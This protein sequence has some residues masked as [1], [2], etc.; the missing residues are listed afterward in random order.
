M[1]TITL[2][3]VPSNAKLYAKALMPKK[4][5]PKA[6]T[7]PEIAYELKG[8]KIKADHVKSY[9]KTCGFPEGERVPACYP[10]LMAM[11]LVTSLVLE[12]K[13]PFKAMGMVHLS[14]EIT[15]L[16]ELFTGD[17][18]DI[19]TH[20]GDIQVLEKGR[21]VPFYTEAKRL[22]KVVWKCTTE[23]FFFGGGHK[24]KE[25]KA[26]T[27]ALEGTSVEW[28]LADGLG[29]KYASVSG[30]YNPIHLYP[31]TAK[32]LGFKRQIIHGMWTKARCEAELL[33]QL[34]DAG[35][36]LK[37]DFKTPVFLPSKV[38]FTSVATDGGIDFDLYNAIG[39]KPHARGSVTLGITE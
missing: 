32:L 18:L 6:D 19:K 31:F 23:I 9:N 3:S 5:N 22:G 13:F 27:P 14:N 11:P 7:L 21:V 39:E 17:V 25:E 38:R 20:C 1:K 33:E 28:K 4:A 36:S 35:Y 29:R 8:T 12:N 10:F 2:R 16:R 15:V 34:P 24:N 30:D 37:I 26:V